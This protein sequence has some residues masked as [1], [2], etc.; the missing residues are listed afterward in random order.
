MKKI[1]ESITHLVR[2]NCP[3]SDG[4]R[5]C[6]QDALANIVLEIF[7]GLNFSQEDVIRCLTSLVKSKRILLGQDADEE[8]Q[9]VRRLQVTRNKMN[10]CARQLQNQNE[11]TRQAIREARLVDERQRKELDGLRSN[12][13]VDYEV[14]VKCANEV[15]TRTNS[16]IDGI[17]ATLTKKKV[18]EEKKDAMTSDVER[19]QR[20][21]D[22]LRARNTDARKA[23]KVC[24]Q[25]AFDASKRT[26]TAEGS[27]QACVARLEVLRSEEIA[28]EEETRVLQR[29]VDAAVDRRHRTAKDLRDVNARAM[30]MMEDFLAHKRY[31]D[32][33]RDRV[34]ETIVD[35][36]AALS[37][38]P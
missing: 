8:I 32:S 27:L 17:N 13:A 19:T 2:L 5:S 10:E 25:Q 15:T 11:Q 35:D 20:E 18:V 38:T 31:V 34:Y 30:E 6:M 12:A 14:A 36:T 29:R 7:D 22:A 4:K 28:F 9:H 21:V 24:K 3:E 23:L 26:S 37:C 33:L 16:V 1:V